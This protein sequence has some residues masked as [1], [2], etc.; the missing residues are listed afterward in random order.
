MSLLVKL[1]SVLLVMDAIETGLK[2]DQILVLVFQQ[3]IKIF[4]S[5][6]VCAGQQ[7]NMSIILLFN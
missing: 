2:V 3:T 7:K 6:K 5:V 4:V 1:F